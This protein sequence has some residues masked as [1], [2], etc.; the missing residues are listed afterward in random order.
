MGF[1]PAHLTQTISAI[2]GLGTAAFGLL[3][4]IKPVVPWINWL[5]FPGIHKTVS[6]LTPA[7]APSPAAP[8]ASHSAAGKA[9][10]A[11]AAQALNALDQSGIVET[12]KSNWVNGNDLASQKAIAKSLIKLHL[13][14]Q[15]AE[16]V[17]KAAN[18]DGATL[19]AVAEKT[20]N[21]KK[22]DQTES[23]VFSRFDLIVTAKLDNCYQRADQF[24][25]NWMRGLAAC[26]AVILALAGV[27]VL[28]GGGFKSGR[29]LALAIL[30][31]LLATPLAPVAKDLSTALATA[32]NTMQLVKKAGS[33]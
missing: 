9:N 27:W 18:V 1:D 7:G 20:R 16:D 3:E 33:K 11:D 23:D 12:L 28:D 14:K 8:A 21:G 4:A 26:I 31:G 24:F 25:R 13:S 22:L 5:G 19:K 17:A 6:A 2:G 32:V 10:G 29:D 30:V 15:N